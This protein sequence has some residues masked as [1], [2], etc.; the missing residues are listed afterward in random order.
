M[1]IYYK[2][3]RGFAD[4][5]QYPQAG[6][7]GKKKV[8]TEP[9]QRK[10]WHF[11]NWKR[12]STSAVTTRL[13]R[14]GYLKNCIPFCYVRQLDIYLLKIFIGCKTFIYLDIIKS[15][16][17]YSCMKHCLQLQSLLQ[18][19]LLLQSLHG[20]HL[21]SW[22]IQAMDSRRQHRQKE[23]KLKLILQRIP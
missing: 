6:A 22:S 5:C 8:E 13:L 1:H 23:Q 20:H 7:R 18:L 19:L 3:T 16:I 4:A 10:V 2:M 15:Q 9:L 11:C 14:V 17:D 21:P 12:V